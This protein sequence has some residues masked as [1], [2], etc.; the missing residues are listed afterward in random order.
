MNV[1]GLW[2]EGIAKAPSWALDVKAKNIQA[3]L[4]KIPQWPSLMM[5]WTCTV[6]I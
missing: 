2:M 1:T 4:A 5:V 3:S 6:R